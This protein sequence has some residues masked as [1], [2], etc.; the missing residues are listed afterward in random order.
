M[1]RIKFN[2]FEKLSEVNEVEYPHQGFISSY[3]T[4]LI[5]VLRAFELFVFTFSSEMNVPFKLYSYV[6]YLWIL[7]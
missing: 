5:F 3:V 6:D 2:D 7:H 4:T 1:T